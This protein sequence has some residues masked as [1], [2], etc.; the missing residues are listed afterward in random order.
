MK[1]KE[2]RKRSLHGRKLESHIPK[3]AKKAIKKHVLHHYNLPGLKPGDISVGVRQ[4]T[5]HSWWVGGFSII[6]RR[7]VE[8]PR[9]R[10]HRAVNAPGRHLR[11]VVHV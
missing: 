4:I 5:T 8:W 6:G 9:S 2:K 11:R 3:K 10:L 1:L 7:E